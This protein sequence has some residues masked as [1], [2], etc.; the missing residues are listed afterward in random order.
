MFID[1]L[2]DLHNRRRSLLD[3][4]G[5]FVRRPAEA[6]FYR[7]FLPKALENGWLRLA[8]ITQ[9]GV[10][11]AIQIGY[12]YNGEFLQMQEGFNPDYVEG[13]GNVLRHLIMETSITEGLRNYDFLGGF[14]EHKRRWKAKER[15]G[16]DLLIARP[17]IKTR[18]LFVK[19]IWPTGRYLTQHGLYDGS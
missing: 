13:A 16:H 15:F 2:F 18:L 3:D 6:M 12:A 8:A 4:P 10:I 14:S 7:S 5:C 1:A 9:D 11:E 19:E 17:S